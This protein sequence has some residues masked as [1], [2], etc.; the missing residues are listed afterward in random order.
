[1]AAA[2]EKFVIDQGAD[3]MMTIELVDDDGAPRDLSH[4][5][6]SAKLKKTYNSDSSET[7]PFHTALGDP[8]TSG[9]IAMS[10]GNAETDALEPGNYVYDVELH[11]Q[12]D[13]NSPIIV[14]RILEGYIKVTPSVTR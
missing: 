13:S 5:T 9:L 11:Y 4:Y 12:Y 8:V 3:I 2:Y 10:L 7:Y 1:M 14:E 6:V